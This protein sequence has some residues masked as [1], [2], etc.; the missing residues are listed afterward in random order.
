MG[1]PPGTVRRCK[2]SIKGA[3]RH[4]GLDCPLNRTASPLLS[5]TAAPGGLKPGLF[6][7]VP[8]LVGF[9]LASTYGG[10]MTQNWLI[11]PH[12]LGLI[13]RQPILRQKRLFSVIAP[14]SF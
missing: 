9:Y 5:R 2:G 11:Y 13:S 6:V 1:H 14:L 7:T 10:I 4:L 8:F 3:K 12:I